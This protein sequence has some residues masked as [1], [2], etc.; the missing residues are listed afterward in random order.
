MRLKSALSAIAALSF[1]GPSLAQPHDGPPRPELPALTL[2]AQMTDAEIGAAL[3]PWF[4][5]MTESGLFNGA[6]IVARDGREIFTRGYGQTDLASNI[7]VTPDTRF[8][9]ASINKAFT[10]VAIAR[11]MQEGRLTPDTTIADIIP[12]YP[13]TVSRSATI[14]Q[15]IDHRGGVADIVGP[16]FRDTSKDLLTSNTDFYRLVSSQPPLFAPGERQEYC[17][18]CYVVLGEIITR[19]SGQRY[20]DYVAANVFAPA[21]MT[22]CAFLRH[23]QLPPDAAR[24]IGRPRGPGTPFEDVSRFH[25]VAGSGAGNSYCSVRDL[26][27]FDNALREQRLLDAE[28]TAQVLRGEPQAGRHTRRIGFAGGGPGVNGILF[29]N[30]AWTVVVLTNRPEPNGEFIGETVFSLLAGPRPQ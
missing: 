27:A 28:F 15:L 11:L 30:G 12:D 13:N 26:L 10:H 29:G 21:G 20:E 19:V 14:A 3:D 1:A 5:G 17:N 25:G 23:D 9:I 4:V 8:P 2:N 24:F 6:V 16:A 18:G 7:A 22:G